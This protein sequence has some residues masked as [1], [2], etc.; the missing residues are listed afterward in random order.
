MQE[1]PR[2]SFWQIWNMSFGFLGIQFGWGLQLANM[3]GIYTYLGAKPE[4][5]PILWLA[6]PVTGL[7][8]QPV[9][10]SMSDRTW[11]RLGRRR[12]YFLVGAI[13]ASIALYFMPN[14]TALWMAASLLW[15]LDASINVSMEPFRAF[16]ADKL[17]VSQRTAGF[18]MQSFFIGVGASLANALPYIFRRYGVDAD[19]QR[20]VSEATAAGI[21]LTEIPP[22]V[23]YSFKIGAVVFL[24]A[25]LWTVLT[26]REYPPDDMEEFERMR[27][28]HKGI[29]AGLREI[30]YA[31]SGMPQTMKQ[32][33][34]VQFFTW[35]GLFCMWMFFGL[36]TS[37]HV[38]GAPND[39]SALFKDGQAWGGIAFM[40][41]SIV[42]FIVAFAL[43]KMASAT[44]RKTVHAVALVCGGV[45]LLASY[46]IQD[47]NLLLLTMVGVGIAWA[48]ILSMPYA[49]LAG[50]LPPARMGVY[51][52]IFNFFIV[53]PEII[54]S[55]TF[56][57]VI[58]ALFGPDNP[59]APLYVVMAGGAFMLI[60]A[61]CVSFVRDVADDVSTRAVISGDEHEPLIPQG[62]AQ[63]V[64]STG[65]IDKK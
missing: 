28:E 7:L 36:M 61:A 21:Q 31:F 50:A 18:V 57:P 19:Y 29:G 43:P 58:R 23:V 62:S 9:I 53:I 41:Y 4:E 39:Q 48:S 16:V 45:G 47:K 20:R 64:P 51:M 25:V 3:S 15:V 5:V 60:A 30:F 59:R 54:A 33:A 11:N 40:V 8:V 24:L 52:G 32:L 46:F 13:L 49:M 37:Y 38:Y 56:G 65:L 17:N 14:S 10:G 34:V 22:S 63:P 12:P 35:L 42:C 26:T 2:L 1:K 27:R 55:F 6:G 44:S